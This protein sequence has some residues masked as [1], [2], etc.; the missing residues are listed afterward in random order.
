[1]GLIWRIPKYYPRHSCHMIC[2]VSLSF[3]LTVTITSTVCQV[4]LKKSTAKKL[5]VFFFFCG[6]MY[7]LFASLVVA[8]LKSRHAVSRNSVPVCF[9]L[10]RIMTARIRTITGESGPLTDSQH[11]HDTGPP[12]T[13]GKPCR[14]LP[15]Q[16]PPRHP[17]YHVS[18]N[19]S[20]RY[21][22]TP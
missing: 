18:M 8:Y 14:S 1:M 6:K 9:L 15:A 20:A 21:N 4:M 10:C 12:P 13:K 7:L 3:H 19:R 5:E 2:S 11:G 17:P 16:P 22:R